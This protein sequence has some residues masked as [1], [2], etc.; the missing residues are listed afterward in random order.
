MTGHNNHKKKDMQHAAKDMKSEMEK[1]ILKI[2]AKA[3]S[4]E[5]KDEGAN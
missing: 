2:M 3:V 5:R 1:M 4:V